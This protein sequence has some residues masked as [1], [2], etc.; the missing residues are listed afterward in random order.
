MIDLGTEKRSVGV[1]GL[2]CS[3]SSRPDEVDDDNLSHEQ[4]GCDIVHGT[5]S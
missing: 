2:N 3:Q 1:L 4:E 5:Y